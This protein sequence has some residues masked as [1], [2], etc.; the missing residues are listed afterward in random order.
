TNQSGQ[1]VRIFSKTRVVYTDKPE[2]AIVWDSESNRLL[3]DKA[4]VITISGQEHLEVPHPNYRFISV[5]EGYEV[6]ERL[7]TREIV[8]GNRVAAVE[9]VDALS[10]SSRT[11]F[12]H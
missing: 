1:F 6:F 12:L 3:R 9:H 10:T 7:S 11:I 4:K 8:K 5:L 2:Q